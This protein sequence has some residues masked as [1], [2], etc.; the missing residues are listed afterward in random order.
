MAQQLTSSVYECS[1]KNNFVTTQ[2]LRMKD[3]FDTQ[4]SQRAGK[5][6]L[7][8]NLASIES[9]PVL[10]YQIP[11]IEQ[12]FYLQIWYSKE[13]RVDSQMSLTSSNRTF[14][15]TY[16]KGSLQQELFC[17]TLNN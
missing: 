9:T 16:H 14:P 1:F 15:A 11:F 5:I 8:D 13:V 3:Y 12:Q 2:S 4:L 10:V 7:L 17:T 6:D